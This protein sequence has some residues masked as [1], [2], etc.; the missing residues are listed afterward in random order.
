MKR[1]GYE[2]RVAP[3]VLVALAFLTA[4]PLSNA[5]KCTVDGSSSKVPPDMSEA[6]KGSY[7]ITVE[8]SDVIKNETY[9]VQEVHERRLYHDTMTDTVGVSIWRNGTAVLYQYYPELDTAVQETNGVCADIGMPPDLAWGWVDKDKN[10]GSKSFGPSSILRLV[11]FLQSEYVSGDSL[12]EGVRSDVWKACANN[13]EVELGYY[14]SKPPWNMPDG[15]FYGGLDASMPLKMDVRLV[16]G[17]GHWIYTF[18]E[19]VPFILSHSNLEPP[20]GMSCEGITG[21]LTDEPVPS[22]PNHFSLAEELVLNSLIDGRDTGNQ[23]MK[24]V[25]FTYAGE[26]SLVSWLVSMSY[27]SVTATSWAVKVIQDFN[28][29]VQYTVYKEF[30]NCSKDPISPFSFDTHFG[31]F[32]GTGTT[33]LSPNDIFHLDDDFAYVG[34]RYSRDLAGDLWTST[35]LDDIPDSSTGWIQNYDKAV[36][37]YYFSQGLEKTPSGDL[38][39][40]N[41]PLRGDLFIY[42]KSNT[43]QIIKTMTNNLYD[44]REINLFSPEEFSVEGCYEKYDDDWSYIDIFFPVET[45]NQIAAAEQE[46]TRFKHEVMLKMIEIGRLSPVRIASIDVSTGVSGP[47]SQLHRHRHDHCKSQAAGEGALYLLLQTTTG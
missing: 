41:F 13:G 18:V 45:Y 34:E 26:I 37:E 32:M 3:A 19:F 5:E 11:K 4:A 33:L 14:Y 9:Y 2:A 23:Y 1:H 31:G 17:S 42:N 38:V 10:H 22:I 25:Q 46:Q 29:G 16:D 24:K 20:R 35:R 43:N 47:H 44:F 30:G 6:L 40:T 21:V 36:L 28:T 27:D 7:S 15:K 39:I 8:M 12:D